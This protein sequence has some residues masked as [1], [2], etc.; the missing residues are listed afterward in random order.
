[1][2]RLGS[3]RPNAVQAPQFA[4]PLTQLSGRRIHQRDMTARQPEQQHNLG[5]TP[6]D[7]A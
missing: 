2:H 6:K 3:T 5:H 4:H 1:M 7:G